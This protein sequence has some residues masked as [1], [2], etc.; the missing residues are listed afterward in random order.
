MLIVQASGHTNTSE[1]PERPTARGLASDSMLDDGQSAST[2]NKRT[3]DA[4]NTHVDSFSRAVRAHNDFTTKAFR[5]F[6]FLSIMSVLHP[7]CSMLLRDSKMKRELDLGDRV[8][9]THSF[10]PVALNPV[11]SLLRNMSSMKP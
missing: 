8:C 11:H 2:L 5:F 4:D 9:V 10:T 3:I 7:A 1:L 6:V